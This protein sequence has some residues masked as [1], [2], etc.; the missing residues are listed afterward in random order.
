MHFKN[1]LL[2][3]ILLFLASCAATPPLDFKLQYAPLVTPVTGVELGSVDVVYLNK[4]QRDDTVIS[5]DYI[6]EKV[7]PN[8]QL[9]LTDAL[10]RSAMFE[11]RG[12]KKV[13]VVAEVVGFDGYF[14]F[15][16]NPRFSTKVKYI[17]KDAYTGQ[18]F[19]EKLMKSEGTVSHA[20][21]SSGS[22]RLIL[23]MNRAV[24]NSISIFISE[25]D[26]SEPNYM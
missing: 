16:T 3:L 10:L 18:V 7:I 15:K 24:R 13:V 1:F 2:M 25:L 19:F 23:A 8:W 22:G 5:N 21:D 17:V 26:A 12:R 4:D 14:L 20:D 6:Q 11:E 9:G